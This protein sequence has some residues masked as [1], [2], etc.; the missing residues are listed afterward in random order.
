LEKT[1][2]KKK[3]GFIRLYAFDILNQNKNI[4]RQVTANSIVDTRT[5]RLTRY[6]MLSFT[7]RMNRFSG[8]QSGNNRT[9][10]PNQQ[11]RFNNN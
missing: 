4:T 11:M 6:V 2:L 9:G 7:Y 10:Q 8:Q 1:I 5:N 3:N